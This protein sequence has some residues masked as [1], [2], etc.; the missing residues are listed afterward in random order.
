MQEETAEEV[1][2]GPDEPFADELILP[3]IE[4]FSV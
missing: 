1:I 4:G 2:A 3:P